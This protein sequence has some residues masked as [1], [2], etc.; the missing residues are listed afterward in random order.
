M[1]RLGSVAGTQNIDRILRLPGTINLPNKTKRQR[2][3]VPCQTKLIHFNGATCKL[4]DFPNEIAGSNAKRETGSSDYE[5]KLDWAEVEKHAGWLKNET[6][7]PGDF[8]TKGRVIIAHGG[9]LEDLNSDL[10]QPG[11]VQKPYTSW[12]EV[13]LALAAIFKADGRFTLAKIAAALMCPPHAT[14]T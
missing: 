5:L 12:S 6:A 9:N 13:S 4:S 8:N 7:L 10:K 3:R 11:L 14:N 1:K 2:G